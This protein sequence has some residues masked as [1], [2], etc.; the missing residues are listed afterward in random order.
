[1]TEYKLI[2]P[3][4]EGQFQ[5]LY[6]G[7]TPLDAAHE[8]WNNLSKNL[9]NYIPEFSFTVERV[10]DNKMFHY[11][12]NEKVKNN[13]V[14]FTLSEIDVK[15]TSSKKKKF[16]DSFNKFQSNVQSGGKSKKK[17]RKRKRKSD[18]SDEDEDEDEFLYNLFNDGFRS[19]NSPITYFWYYPNLYDYDYDFYFIPNWTYPLSPLT[20][21]VP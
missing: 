5:K 14:D 3:Y 6:Q 11:R 2:N 20:I 7:N 8:A 10:G 9:V 16:T 18:D 15:L 17:K 12:V 19:W 4:I 13:E 1:M 21:I